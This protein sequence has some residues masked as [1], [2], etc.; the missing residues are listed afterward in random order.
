M[1][2]AAIAARVR[3]FEPARVRLDFPC[4]QQSVHGRPLVYLDSASSAQKPQA[5]IDTLAAVLRHDYANIHRGVHALSERATELHEGAREKVRAFVNAADRRKSRRD[6]FLMAEAVRRHGLRTPL[7]FQSSDPD[8][9]VDWAWRHLD[10]PVIAKPLKSAASDH[11]QCCHNTDQLRAAAA[12]ILGRVIWPPLFLVTS[13]SMR[14]SRNSASS[15]P[16]RYGPR[17]RNTQCRRGRVSGAGAVTNRMR[18]HAA[19]SRNAATVERPVVKN[20]RE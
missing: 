2:E 17:E 18:N 16:Y 11:V 8:E 9:L 7:Q 6:K 1:T 4:L 20:T 14:C 19:L 3:E 5:V 15:S 13:T 10:W 12:S